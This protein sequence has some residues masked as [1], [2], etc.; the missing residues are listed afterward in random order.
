MLNLKE[1]SLAD[2]SWIDKIMDGCTYKGSEYVFYNNYI[3]K[4]TYKT[5]VTEEDGFFVLASG[6]SESKLSYLYPWGKGD[7]KSIIE[8]MMEDAETRKIPF[9]LRG[10]TTENRETLEGIF[11]QV[12]QYETS[13]DNAEY[14]YTREKLAL[15]AGKKLHAKRNFINRFIATAPNWVFEEMTE[16][17][18][19]DIRGFLDIWMAEMAPADGVNITADDEYQA[20]NNGLTNYKTL[21]LIGGI[22][23]ESQDGEVLA[24][25][26]GSASP[27]SQTFVVHGEKALL[28][29]PGC[30]PMINQQMVKHLPE[31]YMFIN[32]EDDLGLE[33]LR[34]AKLS[35]YPDILEEKTTA[36]QL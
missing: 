5:L 13:R 9:V 1:I 33:G 16:E 19:P 8:K 26:F 10:L 7:I 25:S 36:T 15:L 28:D 34:K 24:F 4:D 18:I 20:L 31:Q 27:N 6:T 17:N 32:R 35:Y 11:P 23:R 3:W 29:V 2:K 30:Y 21:G 12:F 22:L 14:I